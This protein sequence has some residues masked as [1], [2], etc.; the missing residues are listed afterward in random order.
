MDGKV[1]SFINQIYKPALRHWFF[2]VDLIFGSEKRKIEA[3][4]TCPF[5][6]VLVSK[7]ERVLVEK[8]HVF[9]MLSD[10]RL[11]PGHLLVI[12][13]RHV[14][15]LSE[16]LEAERKELFDVVIE[17]EE[18]ILREVASGC[19]I[20]QHFRP[21]IYQNKLKV[22]HLHVHL[23]PRELKD[24]LYEKSQIYEKDVFK[25]LSQEE[26]DRFKKVFNN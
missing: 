1:A 20:G 25:D 15:K 8:L 16:L 21:F 23:R 4:M 9:V 13:K 24:E 19:D 22:N 26:F 2:F 5:C 11:M 12:P 14:E 17:A 3:R 7:K 10:P 18:K 6:E